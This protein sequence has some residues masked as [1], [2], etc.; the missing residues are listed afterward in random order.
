MRKFLHNSIYCSLIAIFLPLFAQA[1]TPGTKITGSQYLYYGTKSNRTV[2][3]VPTW[4][5]LGAP[6]GTKAGFNSAPYE[7]FHYYKNAFNILN[8]RML[9]PMGYTTAP[10]EKYPIVIMLHG[11]GEG[12]AY[13]LLK[14]GYSTYLQ[15]ENEFRNNSHQLVNGGKMHLDVIEGRDKEGPNGTAREFPGFVLFPQSERAGE[16]GW[17]TDELDRLIAIIE[18]FLVI[19]PIDPNRIYIHGLSMGGKGVWKIV[20]KRPDLFAAMLPMSSILAQNELNY[21]N[22]ATIPT[23]IFQGALDN[24]PKVE[25]AREAI[26]WLENL[27]GTPK[28]SEYADLPHNTWNRAYKEDDFFS[29]MLG[30]SKLTIHAAYGDSLFCEGEDVNATLSI[31]PGFA[32][33]K[34]SKDDVVIP[35]SDSNVLEVEG[36]ISKYGAYRVQFLRNTI[37][38]PGWT[39]WSDPVYIGEQPATPSVSI[40]ANGSTTLPSLD[41]ANSVTLSVPEGYEAYSWQNNSSTT[42]SITV[43]SGTYSVRVTEVDGCL[44]NF[45]QPVIVTNGKPSDAVVRPDG[46]SAEPV[47]A[48]RVN[49]FWNDKSGNETGFEIY[50][51]T[52]SGGPYT[53]VTKTKADVTFYG[54]KG[55]S[56]STPYYYSMRAVNTA[57]SSGYTDEI[58]TQTG[59]DTESPSLPKNLVASTNLNLTSITL[60]WESSVDNDR[61]K[62]YIVY[63]VNFDNS[64]TELGIVTGNTYTDS[65]LA[66]ETTYTYYVV[67][68]D[69]SDN[70]SIKSNQATE[71]T[72]FCG[73]KYSFYIGQLYNSVNDFK[74][75]QIKDTGKIGHFL[76]TPAEDYFAALGEPEQYFGFVYEGYILIETPGIYKFYTTSND[77][78][79]LYIGNTEVVTNDKRQNT[80]TKSGTITLSAGVHPLTLKYFQG[81][82]AHTLTVQYEGPGI[83]KREIPSSALCSSGGISVPLGPETPTNLIATPVSENQIDLSWMDNSSSESGFEIYRSKSDP[84]NYDLIGKLNAESNSYEDIGLEAS[85][86]YYYKIRAIGATGE[87]LFTD[88]LGKIQYAY[89]EGE[90]DVLPNFE[91]LTPFK[92]GSIN[93]FD[94]TPRIL[95]DRFAFTFDGKISIPTAGSYNFYTSSDDGSNLYINGVQVVFNDGLH[96]KEK[97]GGNIELTSGIHNIRVDYFEKTGAGEVLEVR[98]QGPGVPEQFIPDSVLN[99]GVVM[100]TTQ[101]DTEAPS[102]PTAL[103]VKSVGATSV[104]LSWNPSTDNVRVVGYNVYSKEGTGPSAQ[105]KEMAVT[106][107]WGDVIEEGANTDDDDISTNSFYESSLEDNMSILS[108]NNDMSILS[109][110]A[111]TKVSTSVEGLE[112]TTPY[113]VVVKARDAA[114]NLSAESN[115]VT[116]KTGDPSIL[117]IELLDFFAVSK[118][119]YIE[120]NWVTASETNNDYFE[121]LRS[122]DG[123]VF[124]SIGTVDGAGDS[125]N[126]LYYSFNDDLP[127]NGVLYYQLKQVDTNGVFENSRIIRVDFNKSI[128]AFDVRVFPNPVKDYNFEIEMTSSNEESDVNIRITDLVGKVYLNKV[129]TANELLNKLM[130]SKSGLSGG[131]YIIS[132]QQAGNKIQKKIIIE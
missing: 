119:N 69:N 8:Y 92:T 66:E 126:I 72:I 118:E 75:D 131:I 28:Y 109:E 82:D 87:S 110:N 16:F 35:N 32:E 111:V 106:D 71:T 99:F 73:L 132:L 37:Y 29:W 96:G 6:E 25:R 104:G 11:K 14:G 61:V 9:F 130:M 52:T 42:N 59:G 113:V 84:N 18:E 102:T 33:Y 54:D 53:F 19:Y 125:N 45:S 15:T 49:L 17:Q 80:T 1:Q 62:D 95:N 100:A 121:I 22:V 123:K 34:W 108:A 77:G 23:W 38:S 48:T 24:D 3:D 65:G 112:A 115:S 43:S 47:S 68:R 78:S 83:S 41:G 114:G 93:N 94:L 127:I 36:D 44:S 67:A 107:E 103:A 57:G 74:P 46:F 85:T 91:S 79:R 117:P 13:G 64:S 27:G 51:A 7:D 12:G 30:Y 76:R 101:G 105:L 122:L 10:P 97:R 56:P 124:K 40:L 129:Y 2:N 128:A 55:L 70:L 63:R 60:N 116:F 120:L 4:N 31:S 89:Y 81:T 26:G 5:Y 98:Y 90:W 58:S 50:R 20:D 39:D 88:D 21:Q 86:T